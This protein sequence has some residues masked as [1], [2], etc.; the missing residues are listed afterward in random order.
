[1]WPYPVG[2]A[3]TLVADLLESGL[4]VG[5]CAGDGEGRVPAKVATVEGNA[6]MGGVARC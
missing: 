2:G 5:S 3:D 1:M 6:S 4:G